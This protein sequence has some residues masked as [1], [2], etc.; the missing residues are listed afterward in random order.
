MNNT[1][2]TSNNSCAIY[3]R[4]LEIK[5]QVGDDF[6]VSIE[7]LN[8]C[9]A[10]YLLGNMFRNRTPKN[11]NLKVIQ[12]SLR[13][14][15]W[16]FPSMIVISP[17]GLLMDGQHRMMCL[18]NSPDIEAMFVVAWNAPPESMY[19]IDTG[20]MRSNNDVLKI[21]G[22]EYATSISAVINGIFFGNKLDFYKKD[23]KLA[24]LDKSDYPMKSRAYLAVPNTKLEK[25]YL[26]HRLVIDPVVKIY[27]SYKK[28]GVSFPL[29]LLGI[30]I[31]AYK[32]SYCSLELIEKFFQLYFDGE[33]IGFSAEENAPIKL[34][35]K[36]AESIKNS[37]E[38]AKVTKYQQ[39]EKALRFFL[40]KKTLS[41]NLLSHSS[42]SSY[43]FFCVPEF[44]FKK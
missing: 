16:I 1:Q 15:G 19:H 9:D 6:Y 5:E 11:T 44:D 17:N 29:F 26:N 33:N 27:G 40:D 37:S 14:E 13:T 35:K 12:Q 4:F 2:E 39:T 28:K 31:R 3:S 8:S 34:R 7:T 30:F 32:G 43:E 38:Y 41:D 21:L 36:L 10:S 20:A 25:I 24:L 22:Y 23:I 42:L 18:E